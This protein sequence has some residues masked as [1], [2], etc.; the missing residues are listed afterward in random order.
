MPNLFE[1]VGE[2]DID[3]CYALDQ[4]IAE[5]EDDVSFRLARYKE[6]QDFYEG[7]QE[8]YINV[9]PDRPKHKTNFCARSVR[10]LSNF[11]YLI[12]QRFTCLGSRKYLPG[13]M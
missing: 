8:A 10:M 1:Q 4:L 3:L 2:Q 6:Y 13:R 9:K 5:T 12:F 11:T 7:D